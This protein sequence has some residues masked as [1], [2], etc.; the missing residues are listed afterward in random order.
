MQN[1]SAQKDGKAIAKELRR[2]TYIQVGRGR[3]LYELHNLITGMDRVMEKHLRPM[4]LALRTKYSK[5][6]A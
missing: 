5:F 4:L 1:M 2:Q 6:V 3:V